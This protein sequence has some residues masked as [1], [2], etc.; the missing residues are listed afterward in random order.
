MAPEALVALV[1]RLVAHRALTAVPRAQLVWLA[2][3]SEIRRY[4]VGE[5]IE[6]AGKPINSLW[7]ILEGHFDIRVHR[8]GGLRRVMEWRGGDIAGL[9]PFSRMRKAPGEMRAIAVTELLGLSRASFPDLIR[10]CQELTAVCV[11]VMLD[12]ARHF[13]SSDLHDEKLAS[14]GRLA[15]GLAHELNNPASAVASNAVA[16]VERLPDTETA[17]RSLGGCRLSEPELA[18]FITL[19]DRCLGG[20]PTALRSPLDH[21]DRIEELGDWLKQ[22]GIDRAEAEDLAETGLGIA[23]LAAA[24]AILRPNALVAALRALAAGCGTRRLASEIERAATRVHELV[25]AVKGFTYMDQAM[26]P[27][28]VDLARGL[29]DTLTVLRSKAKARSV[30][31]RARIED[32]LPPVVGL[33]GELNQIWANLIDNAIDAVAPGGEVE[34]SAVRQAE[35]L[36]VRVVD[37][38]PGIPEALRARVFEPFFTSK[39]VGEGTGLGLVIAH[40]LVL[41]HKG[42][43][44]IDSCPG[45]TEVRVSL[46]LPANTDEQTRTTGGGGSK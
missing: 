13:R 4:A 29:S 30:Q 22:R 43:I 25:A 5:L 34:V 17:F 39:P 16:L 24:A 21:A 46:P 1:D 41:Q 42:E 44:D 14:L 11:H 3:R 38:G 45:R 26:T 6:Q 2:E 32:S 8:G 9:L 28:P 7:V 15:A 27:K 18:A 36:V 12:R 31:L 20:A 37:N 40:N 19:R 10:E 23:D 35:S 33:G